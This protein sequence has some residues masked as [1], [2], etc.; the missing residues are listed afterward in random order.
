MFGQASCEE[1]ERAR[2]E[3]RKDEGVGER[4]VR[5]LVKYTRVLVELVPH[6]LQLHYQFTQHYLMMIY[7]MKI[8]PKESG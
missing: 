3:E 6:T 5:K 8:H 2:A 4:G 1:Q 7:L